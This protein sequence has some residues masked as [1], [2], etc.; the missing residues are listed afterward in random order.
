MRISPP[1]T[2]FILIG[3]QQG[4]NVG[5]AARAMKT[6]G[7]TDLALVSPHD[8]KVLHRHKVIQR[9]S[10]AKDILENANVFNSLEEATHDRNV[11]CG[12]GMPFD[13]YQKRAER[14]YVEPRVLFDKLANDERL[15]DKQLRIALI[16]GSEQKG[17]EESDM[18]KCN[19]M[20]GIPTNPAFGSLNLAAA[21]QLIAYDWR[22][23]LGGHD[24]Y[25]NIC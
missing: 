12:T 3:T 6:M 25:G 4:E 14:V 11:V 13:M 2:R 15:D 8:P 19:V 1:A 17:M 7:F 16:F 10:G 18:D 5:A 9:A 21:V 24:T 23:A 20:L 22:M